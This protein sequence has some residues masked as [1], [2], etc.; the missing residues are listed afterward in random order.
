MARYM[1]P[2]SPPST[3]AEYARRLGTMDRKMAG[4]A[5][6]F[7]MTILS[8]EM[9]NSDAYLDPRGTRYYRPKNEICWVLEPELVKS[10][11]AWELHHQVEFEFEAA[12]DFPTNETAGGILLPEN[13]LVADTVGSS[14]PDPERSKWA[15]GYKRRLE[16]MFN[17][18]RPKEIEI[19]PKDEVRACLAQGGEVVNAASRVI[20]IVRRY[21]F[22]LPDDTSV[23]KLDP[24]VRIGPPEIRTT[25]AEEIVDAMLKLGMVKPLV[26]LLP[27][28]YEDWVA[29]IRRGSALAGLQDPDDW[30]LSKEIWR[31]TNHQKIS[32]QKVVSALVGR[33]QDPTPDVRRSAA[34]DLG[35]LLLPLEEEVVVPVKEV[36]VLGLTNLL[37]DSDPGVR[38]AAVTAIKK[39]T[40]TDS[41]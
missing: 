26:S 23:V 32:A 9:G 14:N 37:N 40:G 13:F 36:L 28:R 31:Q 6:S 19:S 41:P 4:Q 24:L 12:V 3:M 1:K 39:I 35:A 34:E 20:W 38:E 11:P 21:E 27:M 29:K 16:W 25:P 5:V 7:L 22:V 17:K 2:P 8:L 33:L 15:L 18:W 30:V 10:P